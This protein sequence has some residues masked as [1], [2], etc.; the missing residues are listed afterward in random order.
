MRAV[1]AA[2]SQIDQPLKAVKRVRIAEGQINNSLQISSPKGVLQNSPRHV[3]LIPFSPTAS[4]L[5]NL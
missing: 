2:N 1:D 5:N 4:G 3:I